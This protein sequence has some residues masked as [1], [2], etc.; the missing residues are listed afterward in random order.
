MDFVG[1]TAWTKWFVRFM[2]FD[3]LLLLL[4]LLIVVLLL[5]VVLMVLL[6]FAIDNIPF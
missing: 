3:I 5:M 1:I 4:L 6:L 2:S